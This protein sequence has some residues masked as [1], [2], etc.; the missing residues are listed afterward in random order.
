[1]RAPTPVDLHGLDPSGVAWGLDDRGRRWLVRG[2]VPGARVEARG[3][4]KAAWAAQELRPAPDAVPAPCPLY[5]R[6]GGCQLQALPPAR[7]QAHKLAMLQELLAPLGPG[8]LRAAPE[9]LH[10]RDKLEFSFG[11][12]RWLDSDELRAGLPGSGRFL[13]FHSPRRFDRVVDVPD[14]LLARPE[15]AAPHAAARADLLASELPIWDVEA[16]TGFL[17]MLVLRATREGALLL[18]YS[19]SP[20]PEQEAWIRAHAPGWGARGF[21]WYVNDAR[22]DAAI[23]RE[24]WSWGQTRLDLELAGRDFDLSPTAFFQANRGAAELL[25]EEVATFCGGGGRLL[26]LYCGAGAFALTVGR[27]FDEVLGVELNPAA[28]A[29]ARR[30]G[31]AQVH[32]GAVE[33]VLPALG[34]DR[35]DAVV[36]DPPRFGLMPKAR[37][38]LADFRAE[39]LAYVACEPR[40][41]LRDGLALLDGGW[42]CEGW[43]AVDLFPQTRHVEVVARF[44]RG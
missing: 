18:L 39:R 34:I 2:G 17:R 36:V 22:G 25:H 19:T 41:L 12:R 7:Q 1:M 23:G 28:V 32:E 13:G 11:T 26:D 44:R 29:D 40:S 8:R 14:C 10:Y 24:H 43:T 16:K 15:L 9:A 37:A 6:C 4:A 20:A 27:A 42:R 21:V 5:G 30:N 31:L 35:A 3:R 33:E 38:W